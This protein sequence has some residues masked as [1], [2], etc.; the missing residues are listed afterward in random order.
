LRPHTLTISGFLSYGTEV[1]I[2]F[3][4][5]AEA[6]GL[7]LIHGKTGAGKTSILDAMSFALFG[8]LPGARKLLK[9]SLRS[10]FA[11]ESIKTF[12]TF[13]ATFGEARIRI[14]RTP[15]ID[16]P[17]KNGTGTTLKNATVTLE[18]LVAGD[19]ETISTGAQEADPEIEKYVGLKADQ[20]FKL[21]LLPQGDFAQFL[22]SSS[23]ERQKILQALFASE[24][25][26]YEK[27]AYRFREL[28]SQAE[29]DESLAQ[30]ATNN[31]LIAIHTSIENAFG[32]SEDD[33]NLI[34]PKD[35]AEATE[36]VADLEIDIEA[37]I[38]QEKAASTA[39][40]AAID[41]ETEVSKAFENSNKV[42]TA[43]SNLAKATM[44]LSKWRAAKLKFI[45]ELIRENKV[46][47]HL[48]AEILKLD[49]ELDA[50]AGAEGRVGKLKNQR[51]LSV[52]LKN[53]LKKA[54]TDNATLI[55]TIADRQAKIIKFEI[56]SK[57]TVESEVLIS[58]LESQIQTTANFSKAGKDRDGAE[59][60]IK[61]IEAELVTLKLAAI[62]AETAHDAAE[63]SVASAQAA[64]LSAKLVLGAPCPVCGS[65]EHPTPAQ[66]A[67]VISSAEIKKLKDILATAKS[68]L[69]KKEIDLASPKVLQEL[70]L[71][72][73]GSKAAIKSSEL[74]ADL[75]QLKV[76]LSEMTE[77]MAAMKTAQE[78]IE[79]LSETQRIDKEKLP[80]LASEV[81]RL[82]T[83][84]ANS[85]KS[86][87]DI[88]E[89]LSIK[90]GE[91]PET[92]DL[93]QLAVTMAKLRNLIDE[94]EPLL[95]AITSANTAIKTL[96]T[97]PD[98]E[99]PDIQSAKLARIE[100]ETELNKASQLVKY[101][102]ELSKALAPKI[103]QLS[104]SEANL[105]KATERGEKIA[106]LSEHLNGNAGQRIP[107]V[108]YYLGHRLD[109]ILVYANHRLI[110][111][112]RGQFALRSNPNK[113]GAGQN[114]LS[115]SVFDS[116]N[117]G[118]RD[119]S[120]LSGGETFAASL[121]LAFGLA[122]VVTNEAGGKSLESLFIDEGF[123]SLDSEYLN[124]VMES[125]EKLRESGRTIGLIS[126][127]EE[128]KQSI[129]MQLEITK[130]S[131]IG[132]SAR[133]T[134]LECI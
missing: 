44:N 115:I 68:T 14:H 125:L 71:E 129:P 11:E 49:K 114:F 28:H 75:A 133:I 17:K 95:A 50:S 34:L 30:T 5:L 2:D 40:D 92:L 88:E 106:K 84:I 134:E 1:E 9:K 20:F 18:R 48:N 54:T 65:H 128:M 86:E 101:L 91:T 100:A 109:Q 15:A 94:F 29:I 27:V 119:A 24:V 70:S 26:L 52:T 51:K 110:E 104:K 85:E 41:R 66:H 77:N 103:K 72:S 43:K 12:V 63:L 42:L 31:E 7:F 111:M 19:W 83:E 21:I 121:A 53:S 82:K 130:D 118:L 39:K 64:T 55:K 107:L 123:G 117:E 74:D 105:T 79:E 4:R 113:K 122:D 61:T 23:L 132:A 33:E 35:S 131:V 22:R 93:T 6:G 10:D 69:N 57:G 120:L 58:K 126:H 116:W 45:P 25:N 87:R 112:S 3:D 59:A 56:T 89:Q 78:Q 98:A 124:K 16:L 47:A 81:T 90:P 73:L 36:F 80:E 96:T 37:A 102:A 62:K 60:K 108:S 32:S 127:V 76:K 99:V 38:E 8:E 46:V 13:E 67:N 97:D